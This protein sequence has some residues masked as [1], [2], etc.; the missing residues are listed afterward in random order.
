MPSRQLSLTHVAVL[1]GCFDR[2]GNLYEGGSDAEEASDTEEHAVAPA[3]AQQLP[4]AAPPPQLLQAATT[5]LLRVPGE[6]PQQPQ[7]QQHHAPL[8][9]QLGHGAL[10]QLA[11]AAGIAGVPHTGMPTHLAAAQLQLQPRLQLVAPGQ[12]HAGRPSAQSLAQHWQQASA[13]LGHDLAT[14][15]EGVLVRQADAS[16]LQ[17]HLTL[18][19]RHWGAWQCMQQTQHM[20]QVQQVLAATTSRGS[21]SMLPSPR[22]EVCLHD[23]D[24]GA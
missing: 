19:Q 23:G 12:Q 24:A 18:Q 14:Q 13:M 4:A 6:V 21:A 16:Q 10:V 17:A 20:M 5:P 11:A 9:L 22:A 8:Q 3:P 7:P 2:S 1:A 15:Q